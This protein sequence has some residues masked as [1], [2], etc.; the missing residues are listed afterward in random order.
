[1]RRAEW[2]P[3]PS[4]PK[5]PFGRLLRGL[6]VSFSS[7]DRSPWREQLG[8]LAF[9]PLLL[10]A[11]IAPIVLVSWTEG[12]FGLPV[13]VPLA[14][15]TIYYGPLA[16]LK[17]HWRYRNPIFD[18]LAL[19]LSPSA[20]PVEVAVRHR[21]LLTGVD[22]AVAVFVD[23]WLHVD[24][25][26][27]SF[28]LSPADGQTELGDERLRIAFPD[29]GSVTLKLDEVTDWVARGRPAGGSSVDFTEVARAWIEGALPIG[30]SIRP[31]RE[32]Q[33]AVQTCWRFAGPLA[34]GLFAV[35]LPLASGRWSVFSPVP[36]EIG[37]LLLLRTV[38]AHAKIRELGPVVLADPRS[39][40]FPSLISRFGLAAFYGSRR[41]KTRRGDAPQ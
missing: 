38:S 22:G 36:F 11:L 32:A 9:L 39:T 23:G 4:D 14:A 31:P 5:S 12:R 27:T 41:V 40:P 17:A 8:A 7:A 1:M 26:R 29:G 35:A 16:L 21:G 3:C 13:S 18:L 19:P 25:L 34:G 15:A 20:F 10:I 2:K 37:G 30:E 33:A 24:G 28:S 6:W